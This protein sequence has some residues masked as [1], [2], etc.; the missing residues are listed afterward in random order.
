MIENKNETKINDLIAHEKEDKKINVKNISDGHHTFGDL[1][2]QRA[3][4][5]SVILKSYPKSS[6]RSKKH[7][8]GTMFNGDFIVGA[9]TPKGQYTFHFKLK[10]WSLFDGI[11][12]LEKAP[13]YDGHQ[14]EDVDRLISLINNK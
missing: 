2:Y 8:D 3:I 1:Y 11:N 4:M 10:Y 12:T 9:N 7:D 13:K 14:P 5:M 6:F